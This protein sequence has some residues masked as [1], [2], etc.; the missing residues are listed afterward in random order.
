MTL[1]HFV[2]LIYNLKPKAMSKQFEAEQIFDDLKRG[3]ISDFEAEW[4]L[5]RLDGSSC[6][7]DNVS[8]L[9][10]NSDMDDSYGLSRRFAQESD[11]CE[12]RRREYYEQEEY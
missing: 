10:R 6:M 3:R 2:L 1:S 11:N 7:R 5:R 8:R 4:D 12:R 9:V